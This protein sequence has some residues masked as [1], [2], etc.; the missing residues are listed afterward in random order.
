MSKKLPLLIAAKPSVDLQSP[1]IHL[2]SGSYTL[3]GINLDNVHIY[4]FTKSGGRAFQ[5][6]VKFDNP[7]WM[8]IQI[9]GLKENEK[10]GMV[11]FTKI[12]TVYA[13]LVESQVEASV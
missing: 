9:R 3:S 7:G 2:E 11:D 6:G 1:K 13:E 8:Y 4:V 5:E 12:L 10:D